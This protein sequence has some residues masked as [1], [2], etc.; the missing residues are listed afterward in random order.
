[1]ACDGNVH[2]EVDNVRVEQL[3]LCATGTPSATRS[4]AWYEASINAARTHG[5]GTF[6]VACNAAPVA[7]VIKR[8]HHMRYTF[9]LLA[10]ALATL[11]SAQ[12]AT[13]CTAR[14]SATPS[15][16]AHA[17]AQDQQR[18]GGSVRT[19]KV[20]I[21]VGAA[22]TESGEPFLSVPLTRVQRDIDFTN[23][24]FARSNTGIQIQ[25][26]GPI[27]VVTDF[28]LYNM[29][30]ISPAALAPHRVP[31][32]I[33][34]F[35][36]TLLPSGV[37]GTWSGDQVFISGSGRSNT[38][39]H[40]IGHLL[41]LSHTHDGVIEPELADGSNC[42]IGG[43]MLCDT[44]ADPN[45]STPGY[46]VAPCQYVGTVTDANGDLYAPLL[47]NVMSYTPC[48]ADSLTPQQGVVMRYML[49]EVLL[50][51]RRTTHPITIEPFNVLQC[52]NA[53]PITLAASPGPGT[54]SGVY[55]QG[56]TL[57]NFPNPPG[58][59][60]VTYVPATPPEPPTEFIDQFLVRTITQANA[61]TAVSTDSVWQSFQARIDAP[62]TKVDVMAQATTPT[63][64]RMRLYSGVGPQGTLL[65]DTT[66]LVGTDTNWVAF[67]LPAGIDG[68]MFNSYTALLTA[69][70]PFQVFR[71]VGIDYAP[72]SSN[73]A[74]GD[75]QFREW[76]FALPPCQEASRYYS[77]YQ[78]QPRPVLNLPE[79]YCHSDAT[80]TNL[81]VD[82]LHL[83]SSVLLLDGD[84]V[85]TFTPAGLATGPHEVQH[86]YTLDGCTD[87]L[88]QVLNVAPPPAFTFPEL[89]PPLCVED[90]AF[91]LTAEPAGGSFRINGEPA[92]VLDPA[93][94]GAGTHT[95]DYL[96]TAQLD[97]V[98]FFDQFCCYTGMPGYTPLP[99]DT[100]TWQ[101]FTALQSGTLVNIALGLSL[102][103][104][105]RTFDVAIR[106]G[107]GLAGP[108]LWSD[109]RTVTEGYNSFFNNTGL[110]V[111]AG[112][113]YT[114][115]LR[116]AADG[117]PFPVSLFVFTG[118]GFPNGT[119]FVP[120]S[121]TATD[122]YFRERIA[123]LQ[124][125]TDSTS[126]TVEVEVCTG[127]S[128]GAMPTARVAPNPFS[129]QL[130]VG[131]TTD[132][133]RYALHAVDGR[134]VLQGNSTP[135]ANVVL[136]TG[137]LLAGA[138]QLLLWSHGQLTP[139]VVRVM[140]VDR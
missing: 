129:D 5:G 52:A 115:S 123:Q 93:L 34:I 39:A 80:P 43:D 98:S 130:V 74:F 57:V 111:Q 88:A 133:V 124:R 73:I 26:C 118:D 113:T 13:S 44:P 83:T 108:V 101:S 65:H 31:G 38:M 35:Y 33:T 18:G 105:Q 125:C 106:E 50:H 6:A 72:G 91:T 109:T 8:N 53:G 41:G 134:M 84:V 51:L 64:V 60:Y 66:A 116:Y 127:I 78:V 12:Q 47:N 27:S 100:T 131:T 59:T 15:M 24:A 75:L 3:L 82:T 79:A 87:T 95:I 119:A 121:F 114:F 20:K 23:D 55:V 112:S 7:V 42:T 86:I 1:M 63:M 94:L 46:I 139:Q 21:V 128:A 140:K 102:N 110:S 61:H 90:G 45:L 67:H 126:F 138:Y 77:L 25:L 120:G 99:A 71:P 62:I 103:S 85:G 97:S 122:H 56:T 9:V 104:A 49:D 132:L 40:E 92:T 17:L 16:I 70:A 28:A 30:N 11:G 2:S 36:T 117:E 48:V 22:P 137:G 14:G 68:V 81:V 19:I 54:F 96:Y 136:E 58:T 76:V 89:L 32:Y 10:F 69:D 29:D 107:Q 37:G 4:D 135:G